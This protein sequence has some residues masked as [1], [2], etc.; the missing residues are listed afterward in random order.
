[1]GVVRKE[2]GR[3]EYKPVG[4]FSL[5]VHTEFFVRFKSGCGSFFGKL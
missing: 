2:K 4:L 3:P 1:M 5:S